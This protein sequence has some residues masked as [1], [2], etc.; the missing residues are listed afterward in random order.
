MVVR[1]LLCLLLLTGCTC[2]RVV[3]IGPTVC[4]FR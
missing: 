3:P 4:E 1:L 2:Q